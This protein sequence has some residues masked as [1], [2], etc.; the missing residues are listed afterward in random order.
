ML[1]IMLF[2]TVDVAIRAIKLGILR[3]IAPI[4]IISYVDPKSAKDG[5]FNNW[6]K[7]LIS[8]FAELFIK[9]AISVYCVKLFKV[10]VLFEFIL[11]SAE[12]LLKR[13]ILSILKVLLT[14]ETSFS[15]ASL[16]IKLE[17][18]I[19]TKTTSKTKDINKVV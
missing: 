11:E 6:L 5:S 16:F 19:L 10:V 2:F 9:T 3:I 7:A 4:P 14:F 1:V 17:Y 13:T 12:Q 18:T 15:K 8:T